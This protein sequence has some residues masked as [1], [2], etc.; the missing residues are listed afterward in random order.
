MKIRKA[1]LKDVQAIIGLSDDF[2]NDH[3]EIVFRKNKKLKPHLAIR[4]NANALFS[5]YIRKNIKS[6]DGDVFV[7]EDK[8]KLVGY[9]F[10]LI[11]KNNPIFKLRRLGYISDLYLKKPYRN[12]KISSRLKDIAISWFR[13]KGIRYASICVYPQNAHAHKIYGRW[14]FFDYH[15]EMRRKI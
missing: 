12:R 9:L 15:V 5:K 14:G 13:K 1:V 2:M 3:S 8:G 11:K 10:I 7:V 4:K 6:K